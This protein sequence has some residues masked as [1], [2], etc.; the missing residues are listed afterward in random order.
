MAALSKQNVWL[1]GG[2]WDIDMS[3][4]SD[5]IQVW[6][7]PSFKATHFTWQIYLSIVKVQCAWHESGS[8]WESETLR[9]LQVVQSIFSVLFL[10]T[11]WYLRTITRCQTRG[12]CKQICRRLNAAMTQTHNTTGPCY[13]TICTFCK[14]VY[15]R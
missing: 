8:D 15:H 7:Q 13:S 1:S 11:C 14:P 5:I 3:P 12:I 4:L 2:C 6:S 10:W 9:W